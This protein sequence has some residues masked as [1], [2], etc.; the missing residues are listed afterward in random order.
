MGRPG[1]VAASARS[2]RCSP[3]G[4]APSQTRH[5][6]RVWPAAASTP[7]VSWRAPCPATVSRTSAT[8]S[9]P[10]TQ[11]EGRKARAQESPPVPRRTVVLRK[12][13][14]RGLD[15]DPLPGVRY[16]RGRTSPFAWGGTVPFTEVGRVARLAVLALFFM[17]WLSPTVPSRHIYGTVYSDRHGMGCIG[18]F[19]AAGSEARVKYCCAARRTSRPGCCINH[20]SRTV[21]MGETLPVKNQDRYS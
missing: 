16:S 5:S 18:W 13:P 17:V 1:R 6:R 8:R 10:E 3:G 12:R 4:G 9:L 15:D 11:F 20:A 14:V 2:S 19:R 7:R 21:V